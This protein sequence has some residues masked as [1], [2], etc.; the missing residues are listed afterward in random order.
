LKPGRKRPG[1]LGRSR[2]SPGGYLWSWRKRRGSDKPIITPQRIHG[3]LLMSCF[4][5]RAA[6]VEP[7]GK[8]GGS[9]KLQETR[10]D[11]YCCGRGGGGPQ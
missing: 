6:M 9:D 1:I 2:A 11:I 7:P 4:V 3:C 5:C 8:P 10:H